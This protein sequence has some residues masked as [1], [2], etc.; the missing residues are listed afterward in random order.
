MKQLYHSLHHCARRFFLFSFIIYAGRISVS[1]HTDDQPHRKFK[2]FLKAL[3][4]F[5]KNQKTVKK[6]IASASKCAG[7][8]VLAFLQGFYDIAL[9]L[10][11]AGQTK[12]NQ[13][14][15]IKFTLEYWI[16][17]SRCAHNPSV[18]HA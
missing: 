9:K 17:S 3:K 11:S 15:Q 7:L 6:R 16:K 14:K 10:E 18:V 13:L 12:E 2:W 8:N 5:G 1:T 4:I